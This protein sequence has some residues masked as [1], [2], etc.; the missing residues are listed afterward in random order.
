MGSWKHSK[1][2]SSIVDEAVLDR[3]TISRMNESQFTMENVWVTAVQHE[4]TG[5]ADF[6]CDQWHDEEDNVLMMVR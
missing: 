2:I 6:E 5:F 3:I 1:V 4:L